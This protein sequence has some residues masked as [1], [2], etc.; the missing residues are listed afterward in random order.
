MGDKFKGISNSTIIN[1]SH[2]EKSFNKL[3]EKYDEE[4]ANA[5]LRVAEEIE[6][7]GNRDVGKLFNNFNQELGKTEP[8][9]TVLKTMWEDIIK[10]LPLP[11]ISSMIDVISKITSLFI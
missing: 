11:S 3:R 5:I 6:K 2:V 8:N 4:T 10:N 9:K 1:R 7:S